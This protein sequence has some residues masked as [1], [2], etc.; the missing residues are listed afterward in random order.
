MQLLH[1]GHVANF[2]FVFNS[3]SH[4]INRQRWGRAPF[5]AIQL[6]IPGSPKGSSLQAHTPWRREEDAQRGWKDKWRRVSGQVPRGCQKGRVKGQ[7]MELPDKGG[8]GSGRLHPA[9]ALLEGSQPLA[10]SW[11]PPACFPLVPSG[12]E[13]PQDCL[14]WLP[15]S[16]RRCSPGLVPTHACQTPG[17]TPRGPRLPFHVCAGPRHLLSSHQLQLGVRHGDG[18]SGPRCCHP[19][20]A[21][22]RDLC[23]YRGSNCVQLQNAERPRDTFSPMGLPHS[24]RLAVQAQ[25][26]V[27]EPPVP[28][29]FQ[30]AP[31]QGKA[32]LSATLKRLCHCGAPVKAACCAQSDSYR[33]EYKRTN[34]LAVSHMCQ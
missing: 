2:H 20:E 24:L 21:L 12:E 31:L 25:G 14:C 30:D 1:V 34:F 16:S 9:A 27:K 6:C 17:V 5:P 7:R 28:T 10:S 19:R 33:E 29:E 32:Q 18:H 13:G 4:V 8:S 3:L 26:T 23:H 22:V 11:F 15:G